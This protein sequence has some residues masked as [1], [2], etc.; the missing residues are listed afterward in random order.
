MSNDVHITLKPEPGSKL[1][2][3]RG[4]TVTFILTSIH[5]LKGNALLRTNLG[6]GSIS[7]QQIITSIENNLPGLGRDW[8]DIPMTQVTPHEF[9]LR[10]PLNEIGHFKAK[11][12][13][14]AG[15]RQDPVW[16]PG[17]NITINVEPADTCCGNIIYNA[18]VR[19]FGPNKGGGFFKQKHSDAVQLLDNDGYATIPPSG[20]FRDLIRELDFIIGRLGCRFVQLLPIHPTPTTY[21]RMGRFGS[22]YAALSFTA[23]D[24]S[25]AEFDSKA[26]PLEQFIELVE[27][28]HARNAKLLMDIAIN[29][30]GWAASLHETHPEWLVRSSKGDIEVPGAWGVRWEDLTKLNYEHKD[31]WQYMANVFLTWCNRGVD[32]F[33]C[34]AGYMIPIPAWQYIIAVV[35]E[36][37]PDTIFFLEGLGGKV[38]VTRELLD[39]ANF[40]WAYSELFQNYDHPD[41]TFQ[42]SQAMDISK[43]E[44]LMAHYAETH[45][46]PRLASRSHIWAKMRTALCALSSFQGTFGFANGVEWFATE[47]ID[48][49]ESPSLNW[50]A[51]ENQVDHIHRLSELLK[52]HPAFF[53]GTRINVIDHASEDILMLLR[54]HQPSGEKLLIVIN[55]DD[56]KPRQATW[57]QIRDFGLPDSWLD[58]LTG[59]KVIPRVEGSKTEIDLH[60]GQVLCITDDPDGW[61]KDPTGTNEPFQVPHRIVQQRLCAK[62]LEIYQVLNGIGDLGD[63]DLDAFVL[64]LHTDPVEFCREVNTQSNESRVI[65]WVWPRDVRREVMLPPDHFLLVESPEPFHVKVSQHGSVLGAEKS[66][67]SPKGFHWALLKP[68][69]V[70]DEHQGLTL[71]LWIYTANGNQQEETGLMLLSAEIPLLDLCYPRR[72]LGGSFL[73]TLVTNNLGAASF[74]PVEWGKLDSR[75]DAVLSANIN[76]ELPVDR[77]IMLTRLRGWVVYQD[78]SQSLN[79]DCLETFTLDGSLQGE[80]CFHVPTGRGTH[81][82]IKLKTILERDTDTIQLMIERCPANQQQGRLPDA[83][84]IDIILRPD[85][86]NRSFHANT[87]AYEGFEQTW[88][89]A[90]TAGEDGFYFQPDDYHALDMHQEKSAF[91]HEPEWQYMVHRLE[92]ESRGFDAHGDLFSPGY[93]KIQIRGGGMTHL[94]AAVTTPGDEQTDSRLFQS[95]PS[96]CRPD[97]GDM[98]SAMPVQEVLKAA[99]GQFIVRRGSLHT[100]I[101]GYPWFLDWGRDAII[102]TRALIE[103]GDTDLARRILKLFGRFEENGTLPNMLHGTRTSNRETSDAP[104]WFIVACK[105]LIVKENNLSWLGEACGERTIQDIIN[106]IASAYINGT[107]NGIQM[108]DETGLIYSP[109]HYTWMD[110]NH[111][112]GTPREGY[113][114]EIQALWY[115]V[116]HFLSTINSND[117]RWKRLAEKVQKSIGDFFWLASGHYLSDCLHA[118]QGTPVR[119]AKADDALRPNQ[120]LAI[121]MGAVT[122]PHM[123]RNILETCQ[124]LLVPGAIRSLADRP[125]QYPLEIVH[126]GQSLCDPHQPYRGRYEG[127]EDTARKPAYHNGTAWTWLFPSFCEAWEMTYGSQA[128]QTAKAWMNSVTRLLQQ[129]CI[130]HVPENLDG[131]FPH[132]QRGC[133][134]QAWGA[135]EALRV[136]LRLEKKSSKG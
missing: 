70:P 33:R 71:Q 16:V 45:D 86:E 120:L 85:I 83:E 6:Q 18:F 37:F 84:P 73:R 108:D 92:D 8:F 107:S 54:H 136:W 60:P 46:N 34:D 62:A 78:Y 2:R 127:D 15:D 9:T 44:G 43:G 67:L 13:F 26:T 91:V 116:L 90:V 79:G 123:C 68:L 122:K 58:L 51:K 23:V 27:A 12:M 96:S 4:D 57:Q 115:G 74:L 125:M 47:K 130:G 30:T 1:L 119:E 14:I 124:E 35:R 41:I 103:M 56:S 126:K 81:V 72:L 80:W 94:C 11:A 65:R 7:R 38:A 112:A 32:G 89:L 49:H 3:Y 82:V 129:G 10:L 52:H 128:C 77:W 22:P 53:E 105:E 42:L 59:E 63:W 134:A 99:L 75:Y 118:G 5:P 31:L 133:P 21:G 36:Q 117:S 100:V 76:T 102:V 135:S 95:P 106:A 66:I 48:V 88:P 39:V 131:D 40:N 29:H 24:P 110:T 19:Q 132:N 64:K 61:P 111:P 98:D 28:V 20:T 87:K 69:P 104:L 93:F 113:P 50:N 25:L 97:P 121:T 101:A 109:S 55:L 17:S 114:I